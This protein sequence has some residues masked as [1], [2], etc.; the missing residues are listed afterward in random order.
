MEKNTTTDMVN[1]SLVPDVT[2]RGEAYFDIIEYIVL[3]E[4]V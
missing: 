1:L 2:W 3:N 4:Y